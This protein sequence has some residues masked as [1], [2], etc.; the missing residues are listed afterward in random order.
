MIWDTVP[1][2]DYVLGYPTR[3]S[4]VFI[5]MI[6]PISITRSCATQVPSERAGHVVMADRYST[7]YCTKFISYFA[8]RFRTRTETVACGPVAQF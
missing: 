2:I 8:C 3:T 6:D 4:Q 1:W 5:D 7:E